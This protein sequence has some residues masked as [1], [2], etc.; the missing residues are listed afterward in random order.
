MNGCRDTKPGI[1]VRL[2]LLDGEIK[3]K[4]FLKQIKK[5]VLGPQRQ[6]RFLDVSI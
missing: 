2:S 3:N 6:K 4:Q 5:I 1:T